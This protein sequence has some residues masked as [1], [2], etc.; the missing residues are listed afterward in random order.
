MKT[1]LRERMLRDPSP[2]VRGDT[3]SAYRQIWYR[4]P[5]VKEVAE[6]DFAEALAAEEDEYAVG[7]IVISL[8]T[9]ARRRF[10][11][12]ETDGEVEIVGDV[13]EAKERALRY[14]GKHR[15]ED[16]SGVG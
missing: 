11:L 4:M 9:I 15:A 7:I 5:Q 2:L 3:A 10:G 13:G 6:R 8:Q 1:V 16:P 14:L 12:K